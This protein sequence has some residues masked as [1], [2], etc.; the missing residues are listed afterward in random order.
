MSSNTAISP[1]AL[2]IKDLPWQILWDKEKC[3]LCGQCTAVCPVQAI[4]LGVFRKRIIETPV[5]LSEKPSTLYKIYNGIRQRTD[6][7]LCLHRM[8]HVQH[9][10]SE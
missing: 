9:G 5:N 10:M 6:P 3:T 4:E 1:S 7:V 2:S 8:C